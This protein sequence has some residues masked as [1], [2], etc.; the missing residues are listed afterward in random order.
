MVIMKI[1]VTDNEY[2][3]I[4]RTKGKGLTINQY[5]RVKMGLPIVIPKNDSLD[6]ILKA[7]TED[8]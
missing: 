2:K 6:A 4:L 5:G 7:I 3:G 1:E 8:K